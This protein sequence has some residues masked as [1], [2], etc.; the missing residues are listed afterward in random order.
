MRDPYRFSWDSGGRHQMFLGHI[1]EKAVESVYEVRAGR[2]LR[3][4]RTRRAV[5]TQARRPACGVFPL[6]AD[7]AKYG[8]TYPV[9]AFDHNRLADRAPCSD[10][11][12]ALIGGFVYRGQR[13][14][15][16]RGKY[17][18]GDL[19]DGG[20]LLHRGQR[21]APRPADGHRSTS[22]WSTTRAASAITM[23]ELAGDHRVD[24]RFGQDADGELYLLAKANGK[25]W[26]VTGTRTL[27][28][29]AVPGTPRSPARPARDRG[30]R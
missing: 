27:R 26:K 4:E 10:S 18:F 21:D 2:Q 22:S 30:R 11:G 28:R 23:Q 14:P 20:H 6:P 12:N 16:L 25:V 1:G 29:A 7:D 24:L 19:V 8:Y 3:L 17:V 13:S 15:E 5:P 9:A